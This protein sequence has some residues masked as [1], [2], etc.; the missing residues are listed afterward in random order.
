LQ[1]LM[2]GTWEL[3]ELLKCYQCPLSKLLG[4]ES[5]LKYLLANGFVLSSG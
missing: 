2:G 5:M 4:S 3:D 1:I